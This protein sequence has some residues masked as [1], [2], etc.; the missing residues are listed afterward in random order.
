M[1]AWRFVGTCLPSVCDRMG[2]CCAGF[3]NLG[4]LVIHQFYTRV[5]WYNLGYK[6]LCGVSDRCI[7]VFASVPTSN[8]MRTVVWEREQKQKLCALA[9]D[10][11]A[12]RMS[13][14]MVQE[15]WCVR[16]QLG[17]PCNPL[18]CTCKDTTCG[19]CWDA[20]HSQLVTD[21]N[22]MYYYSYEDTYLNRGA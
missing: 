2:Q 18:D 3:H 22:V 16:P 5:L 7:R 14:A 20:A 11:A 8:P 13:L 15:L 12:E 4:T 21:T 19:A 1:G 17:G 6:A 9:A 10:V